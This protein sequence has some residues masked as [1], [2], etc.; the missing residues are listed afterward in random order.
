MISDARA[1]LLDAALDVLAEEGVEGLTLRAI[2]R[3]ANVSH[4]APLKHFPHRA[5]LLAAVA[6]I[7]FRELSREAGETVRRCPRGASAVERLRISSRAYVTYALA[8][9]AMFT[10]MFRHDL[11]DPHDR[12]LSRV[13]LATFDD[14]LVAL[15]RAAQDEGWR[16]GADT[17][18]LT[19]ALWSGLHGLA[20]LWMWGS[21]GIATG[22]GSVDDA[23]EALLVALGLNG[24]S[25]EGN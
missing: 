25:K 14:H 6:T 17:R 4:G 13:S 20:Q 19:G 5:A 12:V 16:P 24:T 11:L 23:I 1:R 15:V 18:L 3:R 22:A 8:H 10:L 21:L 2:A 7:G 9:P